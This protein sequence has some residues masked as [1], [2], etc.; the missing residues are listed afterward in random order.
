MRRRVTIVVVAGVLALYALAG[1]HQCLPHH[2]EHG[3]GASCPLCVLLTTPSLA[4][5][6]LIVLAISPAAA[7]P[8]PICAPIV[9]SAPRGV[10]LLRGPPSV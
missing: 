7:A 6:G 9:S 2:A 3:A 10:L 1:L 4:T 5:A 8:L